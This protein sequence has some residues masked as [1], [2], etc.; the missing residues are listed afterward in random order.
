VRAKFY[1]SKS[2]EEDTTH[3]CILNS[4]Q[5]IFIFRVL[6]QFYANMQFNHMHNEIQKNENVF[7]VQRSAKNPDVITFGIDFG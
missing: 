6:L 4:D 7:D 1:S 5:F 2:T 3:F